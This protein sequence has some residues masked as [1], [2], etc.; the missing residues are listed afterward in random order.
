V[1]SLACRL[2]AQR[3]FLICNRATAF[4]NPVTSTNFFATRDEKT[5]ERRV[6]LQQTIRPTEGEEE[7]RG[8]SL[9]VLF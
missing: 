1:A 4:P 6:G 2:A 9:A 3:R 5:D 8:V 7:L